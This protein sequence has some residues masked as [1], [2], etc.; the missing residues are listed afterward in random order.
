MQPIVEIRDGSKKF[1]IRHNRSHSLKT[2]FV[3]LFHERWRERREEFWA[4]RSIDLAIE[5]GESVGIMGPNGS[6]KSTLLRL[7]ARTIYP[8]SG[9]VIVR[10]HVAPIIEIGVGFHY[11]LTGRENIYL[12]CSLYGL[13][14]RQIDD[15]YPAIVHFSELDEFIDVPVKNYSSGMYARLG[16]SIGVHLDSDI[17][18]IDEALAVGDGQ[19]QQKCHDRIRKI[20][21]QG[22]T[23][24]LVSHSPDAI[25]TICERAILLERGEIVYSGE[26][27]DVA[28]A[29]T[30]VCKVQA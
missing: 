5:P 24:V 1:I 23:I 17:L 15:I 16:F 7:M 2:S 19:F 29:Y 6:G 28:E 13:D 10:G 11:E 9:D 4:L 18:L 20:R 30:A 26:A 3:G 8:T 27:R 21:G 14:R 12:S 22:K 25:R